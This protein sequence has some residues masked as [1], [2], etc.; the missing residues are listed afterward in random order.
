MANKV[1]AL[2]QTVLKSLGPP[3]AQHEAHEDWLDDGADL[4]RLASGQMATKR[5]ESITAAAVLH[6]ACK[7]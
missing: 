5:D 6:P 7:P 3:P 1:E 4:R 2:F